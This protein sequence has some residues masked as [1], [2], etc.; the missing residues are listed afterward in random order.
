MD[1]AN[2]LI[3]VRF[4]IEYS[5]TG[6]YICI[7]FLSASTLL[8]NL[9]SSTI[10][11]GYL[12]KIYSRRKLAIVSGLIGLIVHLL[13]YI[14]PNYQQGGEQN[15]AMISACFFLFGFGLGSYYAVIYPLVGLAV[16]K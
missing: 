8:G 14:L 4:G 13:I 11:F 7:P 9:V 15:H 1:N 10:I 2:T 5:D 12:L 3:Q 6:Y 16:K